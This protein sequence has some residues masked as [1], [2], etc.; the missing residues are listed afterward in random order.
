MYQELLPFKHFRLF[1]CQSYFVINQ[2]NT[3]TVIQLDQGEI[4]QGW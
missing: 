4:F 1:S 3:C 2:G